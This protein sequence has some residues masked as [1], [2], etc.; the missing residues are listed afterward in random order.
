MWPTCNTVLG[1]DSGA[2]ERTE[3]ALPAMVSASRG[4]MV[5]A[6]GDAGGWSTGMPTAR[7]GFLQATYVLQSRRHA[8]CV[9]CKPQCI[10]LVVARACSG[11]DPDLAEIWSPLAAAA[12]A[13]WRR[14]SRRRRDVS[15]MVGGRDRSNRAATSSLFACRKL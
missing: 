7:S 14:A 15:E 10:T 2:G 12:A 13:A 9:P 1:G 3:S 6:T 4:G 8:P 11:T 5:G